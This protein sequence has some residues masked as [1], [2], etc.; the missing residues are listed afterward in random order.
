[1]EHQTAARQREHAALDQAAG[2]NAEQAAL[3]W[4]EPQRQPGKTAPEWLLVSG[5]LEMVWTEDVA[6]Q[7]RLGTDAVLDLP[8][9][10]SEMVLD[11]LYT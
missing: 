10:W 6:D 8:S 11:L 5:M 2:T 3:P 9:H 1:M 7:G 4:Q